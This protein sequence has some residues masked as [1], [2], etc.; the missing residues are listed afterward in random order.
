MELPNISDRMLIL[1]VNL[2][3]TQD[4]KYSKGNIVYIITI[5]GITMLYT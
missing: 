4:I 2:I 3:K 1:I 5:Y